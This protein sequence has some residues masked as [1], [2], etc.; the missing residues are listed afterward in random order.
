VVKI[1]GG[2]GGGDI[3]NA[4]RCAVVAL[5]RRGGLNIRINEIFNQLP[6]TS[7]I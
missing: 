6:I 3:K 4:T 5:I 7:Q 1:S 2:D